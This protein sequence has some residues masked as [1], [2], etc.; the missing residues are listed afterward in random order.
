MAATSQD[1]KSIERKNPLVVSLLG[2]FRGPGRN[3][4]ES[5]EESMRY[6]SE[7]FRGF[8]L[9]ALLGLLPIAAIWL[10]LQG[11]GRVP[12]LIQA[13]TQPGTPGFWLFWMAAGLLT[14]FLVT[15]GFVLAVLI[16]ASVPSPAP[17]VQV[18]RKA[19]PATGHK[20]E[21]ETSEDEQQE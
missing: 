6:P 4:R 8:A 14:A 11:Q 1:D 2:G 19:I 12:A 17:S 15:G 7:L 21:E 10:S 5:T 13:A 20:K 16:T 18:S 3:A 9:G